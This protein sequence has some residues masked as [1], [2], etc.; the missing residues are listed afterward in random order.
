MARYYAHRH[1][2]VTGLV[3]LI[4]GPYLLAALALYTVAYVLGTAVDMALGKR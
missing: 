1:P 3:L 2:A 4:L